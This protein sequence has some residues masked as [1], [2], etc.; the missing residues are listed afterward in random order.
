MRLEKEIIAHELETKNS[1]HT[2]PP[3]DK[4]RTVKPEIPKPQE[5][6]RGIEVPFDGRGKPIES[7][8][9]SRSVI[10]E[11]KSLSPDIVRER[12]ASFPDF[13]YV[14]CFNYGADSPNEYSCSQ[15]LDKMGELGDTVTVAIYELKT[16][17]RA[18]TI[19]EI[20]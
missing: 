10:S 1:T 16:V 5:I 15:S 4:P 3:K 2:G 7:V 14:R 8:D 20:S 18:T 6:S 13:L 17:E 11:G 9:T 19:T 12:E